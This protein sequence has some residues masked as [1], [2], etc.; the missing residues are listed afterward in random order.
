MDRGLP[1]ARHGQEV[2]LDVPRRAGHPAS[3]EAHDLDRG[4]LRAA[5]RAGHHVAGQRLDP[6]GA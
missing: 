1:A 6:G 3:L 4:D 5:K 2:A